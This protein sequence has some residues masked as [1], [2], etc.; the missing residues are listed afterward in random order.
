MPTCDRQ[1]AIGM[2]EA[3]ELAGDLAFPAPRD[4]ALIGVLGLEPEHLPIVRDTD[5]RPLSRMLL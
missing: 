4:Q 3:R 1:S 2:D 5:G